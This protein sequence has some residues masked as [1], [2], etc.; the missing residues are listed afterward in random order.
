MQYKASSSVGTPCWPRRFGLPV[1]AGIT[2]TSLD[3]LCRHY[4]GLPPYFAVICFHKLLHNLDSDGPSQTH[5]TGRQGFGFSSIGCQPVRF[6]LLFGHN[7]ASIRIKAPDL[8]PFYNSIPD[9][10]LSPI[11]HHDFRLHQRIAGEGNP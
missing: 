1:L 3:N 4:F 2:T 11:S 7:P 5:C 9:P 8:Q 6:L 10:P